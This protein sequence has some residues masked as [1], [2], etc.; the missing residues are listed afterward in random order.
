MANNSK[1]IPISVVVTAY[2]RKDFLLDDD[3]VFDSRKLSRVYELMK[4]NDIGYY[5]NGM[6]REEKDLNKGDIQ[7]DLAFYCFIQIILL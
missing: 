3:D 2:N 4:S 5:H 7:A 6:T 1:S